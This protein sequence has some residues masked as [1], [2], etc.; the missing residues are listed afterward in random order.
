L[1]IHGAVAATRRLAIEPLTTSHA[2]RLHAA[3]D[4]PAVAQ[5]L[6]HPPQKT[7]AARSI[8]QRPARI[9]RC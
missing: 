8:E 4:D 1:T 7:A 5:Y 9:T 2:E 6:L 3:L